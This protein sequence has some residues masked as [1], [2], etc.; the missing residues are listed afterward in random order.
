MGIRDAEDLLSSDS[1]ASGAF[2]NLAR[3]FSK[4][5]PLFTSSINSARAASYSSWRKMQPLPTFSLLIT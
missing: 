1:G 2:V 3:S 4:E 5:T